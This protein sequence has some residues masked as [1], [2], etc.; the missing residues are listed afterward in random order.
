MLA[1]LVL[2]RV[3]RA[4]AQVRRFAA[5]GDVTDLDESNDVGSYGRR[6][7]GQQRLT[8]GEGPW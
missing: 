7:V 5:F 8:P 2:W 6:A 1:V 4:D 3:R